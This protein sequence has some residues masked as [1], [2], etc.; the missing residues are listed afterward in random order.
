LQSNLNQSP[1]SALIAFD[2]KAGCGILHQS[3]KQQPQ[4]E[5][6]MNS[7][8]ASRDAYLS[9]IRDAVRLPVPGLVKIYQ[10]EQ[11]DDFGRTQAVIIRSTEAVDSAG[12]V[13]WF[14]CE[15]GA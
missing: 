14:H 2:N 11:F 4:T 13:T 1:Q 12:D 3:S 10:V 15:V 7:T 8:T 6:T 9:I 5:N